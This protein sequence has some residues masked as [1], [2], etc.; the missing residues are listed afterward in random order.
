MD[1]NDNLWTV[2]IYLAVAVACGC[3]Y[4]FVNL[5]KKEDCRRLGGIVAPASEGWFCDLSRADK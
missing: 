5:D 1:D 4:L 3:I 2:F